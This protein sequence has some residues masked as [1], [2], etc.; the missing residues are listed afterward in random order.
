MNLNGL[1]IDVCEKNTTGKT[2]KT[3]RNCIYQQF[4]KTKFSSNHTLQRQHIESW[5]TNP[6][7]NVDTK[8]TAGKTVP[9]CDWKHVVV[10]DLHTSLHF[11]DHFFATRVLQ[12]K[13]ALSR[14]YSVS[15]CCGVVCWSARNIAFW[16]LFL[17][18]KKWRN[19]ALSR[20]SCS[21]EAICKLLR[22]RKWISCN[23]IAKIHLLFDYYALGNLKCIDET[24]IQ[25][26]KQGGQIPKWTRLAV[27]SEPQWVTRKT[28]W[29][30]A[31]VPQTSSTTVKH[32]PPMTLFRHC[33][34]RTFGSTCVAYK[35]KTGASLP[36]L[37]IL[38]WNIFKHAI[39]SIPSI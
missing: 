7:L 31:T 28:V 15:N 12:H 25:W 18:P 3:I 2:C 20:H 29:I 19:V 16:S 30:P 35:L 27:Q 34:C 37:Q 26:V 9:P 4:W 6:S 38:N 24:G 10:E 39:P 13:I 22:H 32:F 5:A 36:S 11:D 21:T 33:F 23:Y 14:D 17:Q 8:T 1:H